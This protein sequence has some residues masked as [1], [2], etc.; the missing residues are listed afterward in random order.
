[1]AFPFVSE[2]QIFSKETYG[3]NFHLISIE[4]K[5]KNFSVSCVKIGRGVVE[6]IVDLGLILKII[7]N[8][9]AIV[10]STVSAGFGVKI[11]WVKY[12]NTLS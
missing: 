8:I 6:M 10:Q 12:S 3:Y 5:R 11:S 7:Y 9:F 4:K 2:K 1:M